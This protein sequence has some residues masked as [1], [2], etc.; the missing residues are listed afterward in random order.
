MSPVRKSALLIA[1]IACLT[2]LAVQPGELGSIDTTRRLQTTHSFWTAAPPV[3]P[4]DY[5]TFG[6]IGRNGR[7]YSW[8]GMGQSALM[9]PSDVLITTAI[10]VV[11]ALGR[12]QGLREVFVSYTVSTAVSVAA[13][14]ICFRFLLLLGFAVEQSIA[15]A[16]TLLLATSFLHYTQNMMENNFMLLLTLAGFCFQYEWVK[17]GST[18]SLVVGAAALGANLLVRLTTGLD[19]M[20]VTFFVGL[21]LYFESGVTP[22]TTRRLIQYVSFVFPVYALSLIIDRGYQFY[23][24]GSFTGTYLGIFI[25]QFKQLHPG[26]APNFPFANPFWRGFIGALVAPEKSIFLFDP[27]LI[28]TAGVAFGMWGRL[29]FPVRAFLSGA[30]ALLL[31]YMAFHARLSYELM[32]PSY[33]KGWAGDVSW[34]DRYVSTPVQLLAMISVPMLLQC[35]GRLKGFVRGTAITIGALSVA[36]QISSTVFWYPLEFCQEMTLPKPVFV[37]GLRFMNIAAAMTGK[38]K[39]WGLT[40]Y[41]TVQSAHSTIPYFYPIWALK[42][43]AIPHSA[44]LLLVGI[45]V[46]MI[47]ALLGLLFRIFAVCRSMPERALYFGPT[48]HFNVGTGESI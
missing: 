30:V 40:N 7:I 44:G 3:K 12:H 46:A 11:P 41:L 36:I 9:L 6:L 35:W 19:L 39:A 16:L 20:A 32:L 18:K 2:A 26:A 43:S 38:T 27:M 10:R 33:Q 13:I 14:L 37:V 25:Q 4:G 45:W 21:C 28:I 34:G 17:T 8:Y 5:P 48:Q 42:E 29:K 24:F 47:V 23:R 15:G 22:R 31:G 1:L